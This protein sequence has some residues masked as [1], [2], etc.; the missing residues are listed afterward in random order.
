MQ[1]HFA[2][3]VNAKDNVAVVFC[4]CTTS[5]T[6]IM[7]RDPMGTESSIIVQNSIP[8][9]H[10][11]ATEPI[12]RGA[13][14]IKYGETIGVATQDISCGEHVHIHNLDSLRGRGDL[15]KCESGA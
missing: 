12:Q 13:A 2:L 9:G 7:V 11:V 1:S 14:I 10:K 6:P 5:Q 15:Q 8:F 4:E 3:K